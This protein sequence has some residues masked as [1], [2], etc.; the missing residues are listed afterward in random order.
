MKLPASIATA[1]LS[2]L[3][4]AAALPAQTDGAAS[5]S[6]SKVRIVR[7]SEV[8]G[9]VQLDRSTGRGFEPAI[10]NLPIV[11]QN[12]LQTGTGVAEVE[13]EDNSSLRLAPDSIVEFPELSRTSAGATISSVHILKGMAYITLM[14]SRGSEFNVLYGSHKISLPPATHIRLQVN[15]NDAKLAVLDGALTIDTPHGP[16]EVSKKKTVTL[17]AA[18]DIN[19]TVAKNVSADPFDAWD[20]QSTEYHARAAAY[21]AFGNSP[22]AYGVSDMMYYGAFA[23]V[24]GCGSMWRPYFASAAWDPYSAGAWAYYSGAG[25][26]W[27]GEPSMIAVIS[28]PIV[29]SEMSNSNSFVFRKDSAGLGIP[30]GDL[31]QLN[32][33]SDH[34]VLKGTASTSVYVSAGSSA[35]SG[36]M[37][38]G[39]ASMGAVS[40]H[41]GSP[42]PSPSESSTFSAR[43]GPGGGGGARG[44]S[45]VGSVSPS[46]APRSSPAPAPG[47]HPK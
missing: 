40:I 25:Y 4:F 7:L 32:K 14:K 23:N 15:D 38:A 45:S 9:T 37:R 5:A 41:R 8:K 19:P 35:G 22:Y 21:S 11:E 10:T 43:S 36:G 30:R 42:P 13:F 28:K 17:L 34:A 39:T 27:A 3:L 20:K 33:F 16:V 2:V 46:S 29:R 6:V 1:G 18:D 31:G 47:G 26:S 24:G 12:R 44:G